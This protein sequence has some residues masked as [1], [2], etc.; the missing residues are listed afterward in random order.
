MVRAAALSVIVK[1][2]QMH[3]TVKL[4][5][6]SIG[7]GMV[8]LGLKYLA[9][10]LTGSVALLSDA[11]ESVVNIAAAAAAVIALQISA[12]PAD[13]NHPYGHSKA[14][15]FASVSEGVLIVLAAL[16]ILREAY[17]N[18]LD[19][20]M[21]TAPFEGMVINAMASVLNGA[22]SWVLI[23]KGREWRSPAL[24][25]DG[26]HLFFDVL[27]SIGVLA[28]VGLVVLTGWNQLDALI[29]AVV[30]LYILWSGFTLLRDSVGGLM[31]EAAS[32]EVLERIR[33]TIADHSDGA[34]EAHDLRTRYA[35]RRTFIEFHLIVSG[36]MEVA[37]AHEI[38]DR[39]EAALRREIEDSTVTIHVEPDHKAK[40][41]ET[42]VF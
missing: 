24:L 35:G 30:A 27:T 11:L 32:D 3:R 41:D 16:A 38:C 28:G 18:A 33:R 42:I 19:P 13:E 40:Q 1:V 14:E 39:I 9:Y 8:V 26:K 31:D 36:D 37:T 17:F 7:V 15:Y 25:T 12:A 2:G 29:A 20:V 10:H 22:W 6:C 23:R 21:I 5:L 4:A 34:L